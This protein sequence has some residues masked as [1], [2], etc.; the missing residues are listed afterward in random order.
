MSNLEEAY[1]YSSAIKYGS[2]IQKILTKFPISFPWSKYKGEL[3]LPGHSFS[4][5]GTNLDKRL[6][7]NDQPLSHSEPINH[8]DEASYKHDLKLYSFSK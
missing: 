4:G 6:D 2:D 7:S 8:I 3:H 1:R 5:P